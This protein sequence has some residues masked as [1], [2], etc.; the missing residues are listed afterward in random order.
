MRRDQLVAADSRVGQLWQVR[1]IT[2]NNKQR[3]QT[4]VLETQ[5]N[6]LCGGIA[7]TLK[8]QLFRC[9]TVHPPRVEPGPL[10]RILISGQLLLPCCT[11]LLFIRLHKHVA[12]SLIAHPVFNSV[13][14]RLAM[15]SIPDTELSPA[16]LR[17]RRLQAR[18][19][20]RMAKIL[21]SYGNEPGDILRGA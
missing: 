16:E 21:N 4:W 5:N 1:G 7:R 13:S 12:A 8:I 2:G 10:L 11:S 3:A 19:E 15:A 9:M 14:T 6:L 20:E 17:K 18:S